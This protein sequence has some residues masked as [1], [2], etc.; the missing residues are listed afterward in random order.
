MGKRVVI[1][2]DGFI[3]PPEYEFLERA[4][5]ISSAPSHLRA[6]KLLVDI[7]GTD[8]ESL[9]YDVKDDRLRI[10]ITPKQGLLS[11]DRVRTAQS[12]FSYDL[13]IAVDAADLA[14]LGSMHEQ[15]TEFF[16]SVPILN[17]DHK[18]HNDYF[19]A[20]NL[21][22]VAASTTAEVVFRAIKSI[23]ADCVDRPIA[24]AILT[25]IVAKT[26]S[27]KN[28]VTKP[29]TLTAASELMTLGADR[30]AIVRQLFRTRTVAALK[31]WGRALQ[32]LQGKQSLGIL[33]STITREDFAR[34]GVSEQELADVIDELI[35]NSS[36]ARIVILLHEH[37][38]GGV[39]A[40]LKTDRG[41]S[42]KKIAERF[43]GAG[44]DRTA[45]WVMAETLAEAERMVIEA[46]SRPSPPA[47][48][49]P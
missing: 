35:M 43:G 25:A 40:L 45:A 12:E 47:G 20:V 31:L 41:V 32:R 23:A 24:T 48:E 42:A 36:G 15:N 28:D 26:R 46:I 13:T 49:V 21:V 30:E 33:W 6:F 37:M 5:S 4:R 34:T 8:L 17:I 44:D 2:S 3:L 27:F 39:H 1:V 22:D 14:S 11:R 9:S 18:A 38:N 10:S 16:Y 29:A 7:S 19:G